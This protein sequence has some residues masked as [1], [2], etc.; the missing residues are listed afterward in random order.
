MKVAGLYTD[1]RV[2]PRNLISEH[3]FCLSV[4]QIRM[5]IND[6]QITLFSFF[7]FQLDNEFSCRGF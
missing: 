6:L 5:A 2:T 1:R 3:N 7:S 4:E